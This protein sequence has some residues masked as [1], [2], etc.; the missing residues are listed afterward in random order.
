MAL[1]EILSRLDP[2]K[3]L[4]YATGLALL[5][6]LLYPSRRLGNEQTAAA[7]VVEI[8]FMGP[9]WLVQGARIDVIRAFENESVE[10]N[11]QDPTQPIYRVISG[12]NAARDQV[13][14]P[15]RFLLAVA[16]GV[17][18]D[19]IWFDRYAVAE[20]AAR[21]AF[22]PLDDLIEKDLR[23]P[24][25]PKEQKIRPED[26]YK[27]CWDEPKYLNK[28]YGIPASMDNRALMYNKDLLERADLPG[29]PRTWKELREYAYQLSEWKPPRPQGPAGW[30]VK[31]ELELRE[32][33]WD[34]DK[35]TFPLTPKEKD[36]AETLKK[37]AKERKLT[38]VG[39][40]PNFGNSWLYMYGWLNGGYFMSDRPLSFTVTEVDF[41][42][43]L[44]KG[45][46]SEKM[47]DA[48]AKQNI[49]LPDSVTIE[50]KSEGKEW[51]I[52]AEDEV[53][54]VKKEEETLTIYDRGQHTP[55]PNKGLKYCTLNHPGIVGALAFMRRIYDD[56]GGYAVVQ[57]FQQG[58]QSDQ[59]DPFILGKVAMK[60]DGGW[61]MAGMAAY[62][63]DVEF[64]V[65]PPPRP[66]KL[67][68]EP[69]SWSGGFA[70]A[71]PYNARHKEAAWEFIRYMTSDDATRI[72]VESERLIAEAQGR[73]YIPSPHPK[74]AMTEE[75]FQKYVYSK[76]DEELP[77]K[78]RAGCR[79]FNDLLP[80]AKFRPVTPVG[81]RL[82]QAHVDGMERGL[83]GQ[84]GGASPE[85][86]AKRSLDA[87]TLLVQ[88][89]VD[90]FFEPPTG[91]PIESW[92]WFFVMYILIIVAS[93]VVLYLWDTRPTF[94]ASLA[95][96]AAY[97]WA[98]LL[99]WRG[100]NRFDKVIAAPADTAVI[101]G[102]RG[103]YF[104]RQW[105]DGLLCASPWIFGFLLFSG[106]PMLFS[107]VMSFCDYDI[108]KP[109]SFIATKNYE[110]MF[111]GDVD[112]WPSLWNSI[113]MLVGVPLG[114]VVSLAMALLLNV[115]VRGV[116]FWRTCFYLPAIV[117]MVAASI[118]WIW[119]FNP[120]SGLINGMLSAFGIDGPNWLQNPAWS[121][122]ALIIMGLWGAGAQMI[123]WLAGLN[124]ISRTLYEAAAVD[125]AGRWQQFRHITIPQLTPYI[126]FNLVMGCI[127]TFQIF[128]QAFIMT[129]GGPEKSTLFYV[130]HLFNNAFRYGNMGYACAMAWVLFLI[131]LGFT[132]V[133]LRLS[134][135]WVHYEAEA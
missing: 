31:K 73:T 69:M 128:T 106:G 43:D 119:I 28:I 10:R 64:G 84:L 90:R 124:G 114:M 74:K 16:G 93:T 131:V 57:G 135:R 53:F 98:F 125:G 22:M 30:T 51:R 41:Q 50:T 87:Q 3:P 18:P 62:G 132:I 104:R 40:A 102:A 110:I 33:D 61:Q 82:W 34:A 20:W 77:A 11:K 85:E 126:F 65:A 112:Y 130:Y 54:F 13:S 115:N 99:V 66:E 37:W 1:R 83:S 134:K 4:L 76:T 63:R 7:N 49:K 89:A 107:I 27:P 118:L 117:P 127:H 94:R 35:L 42:D 59:L 8:V 14:D 116:A 24:N 29:P 60:I 129:Q 55:D 113:Y 95:Y 103:G 123:I 91:Q 19:V 21:D 78:L 15:T 122:P 72:F 68:G 12:Q 2:W 71:I 47:R 44:G 88:N 32:A 121:K 56:A 67:A 120:Q 26:F 86:V 97:A 92:T 45:V 133:Q 96:G 109:P 58:F 108:L 100:P 70:Y 52:T 25:V 75:L 105:R 48:F 80:Y 36:H 6:W 17:P 39:F 9:G 111:A 38:V 79:A 23:D 101:E 81:Q 5:L 46:F